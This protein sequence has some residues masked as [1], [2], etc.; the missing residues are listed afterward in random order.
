MTAH[1][2]IEHD[3]ARQSGPGSVRVDLPAHQPTRLQL[4]AC[5]PRSSL[6]D[7]S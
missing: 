5:A 2:E 1:N 4:I 3:T 7:M 6:S